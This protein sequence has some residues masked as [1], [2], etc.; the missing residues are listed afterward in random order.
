MRCRAHSSGGSV[1]DPEGG[2]LDGS[3]EKSHPL[4]RFAVGRCH[5]QRTGHT[6]VT[7]GSTSRLAS[8]QGQPTPLALVPPRPLP[9]LLIL[10]L[11][12]LPR[13]SFSPRLAVSPCL[14]S[15]RLDS[16]S[17]SPPLSP[18]GRQLR[19]PSPCRACPLPQSTRSNPHHSFCVF[20]RLPRSL[21]RLPFHDDSAPWPP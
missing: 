14:V 17:P 1:V 19:P 8:A 16:H 4:P 9:F 11:F 5:C 21:Q 15:F 12:S 20:D 18:A 3:L 10:K 13:L 2:W 7:R 6:T